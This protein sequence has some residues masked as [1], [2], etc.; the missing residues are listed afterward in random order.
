MQQSGSDLALAW[1]LFIRRIRTLIPTPTAIRILMLFHTL[2]GIRITIPV[3]PIRMGSGA[4]TTGVAGVVVTAAIMEAAS[5]AGE[6]SVAEAVGAVAVF[7]AGAGNGEKQFYT[8]G[9]A[10]VVGLDAASIG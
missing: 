6:N 8:G 1:L 5:V 2:T 10:G 7:A 9:L 3:T 4:A